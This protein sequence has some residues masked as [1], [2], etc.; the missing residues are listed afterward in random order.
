MLIVD[1]KAICRKKTGRILENESISYTICSNGA[2][3]FEL[4]KHRELRGY[5]LILMD[6]DMPKM[7]GV[8]A[9]AAIRA[10]EHTIPI[11]ALTTILREMSLRWQV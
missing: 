9:A 6:K 7:N 3:A 8:D 1:A 10:L 4:A 5:K 2:D 11:V